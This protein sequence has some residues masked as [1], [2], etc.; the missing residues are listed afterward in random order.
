MLRPIR[1]AEALLKLAEAGYDVPSVIS[2]E[3]VAT[4]VEWI[5]GLDCYELHY[6]DLDEAVQRIAGV[7]E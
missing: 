1:R 3:V 4:L 7:A 2:R 6:S 5:A